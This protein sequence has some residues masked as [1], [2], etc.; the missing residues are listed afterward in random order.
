MSTW[1]KSIMMSDCYLYPF[2]I[3]M[4]GIFL[5]T[6]SYLWER[7]VAITAAFGRKVIC[8]RELL[9]LLLHL[10]EK[11]FVRESCC[12]YCS[13]WTES[14]LWEICCYYC[15]IWTKSYLWERVAA[16]TAAFGRKVICER[17]VA[18]TAAFGK[19]QQDGLK[20]FQN[21]KKLKFSKSFEF[22]D[23]LLLWEKAGHS[24]GK[25][26]NKYLCS[27]SNSTP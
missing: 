15:S 12:Y 24:Q 10:D 23:K 20:Y 6:K 18:I 14:Y 3:K 11:L 22:T 1:S 21:K 26:D 9:L 4:G 7:V 16:I 27:L 17:V 8:E 19:L 2:E 13:I 25:V 5:L